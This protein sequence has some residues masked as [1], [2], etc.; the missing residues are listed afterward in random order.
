MPRTVLIVDDHARF[1]GFARRLLEAGGYTVVGEA[2]DGESALS[3]VCELRP[4]L[5]LLDI[6]LPDTD[7]FAVA[8]R[9]A[10]HCAA[11]VVVLTSSREA[12]DF[13]GRLV[14]SPARGFIHKDDLSSAAL[15]AVAG[16]P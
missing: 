9:L 14:S 8:E 13:G 15:A 1:R 2:G 5:V 6:V 7:G 12:A 3:A 11:P 4:Q 10:G 16:E